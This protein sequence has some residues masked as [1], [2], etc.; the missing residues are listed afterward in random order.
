MNIAHRNRRRNATRVEPYGRFRP[1]AAVAGPLPSV[2]KIGTDTGQ[3]SAQTGF[4]KERQ[5]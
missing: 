3:Q 2:R 1:V 5:T 4:E